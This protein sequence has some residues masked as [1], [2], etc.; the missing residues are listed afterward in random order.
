MQKVILKG[1]IPPEQYE[2]RNCPDVYA[3]TRQNGPL[4]IWNHEKWLA[5]Q[6]QDN[7]IRMLGIYS[8]EKDRY[9]GTCGLT[10]IN[11]T[12]RTAEFSLFI[13]PEFQYKGFG[14]AAL[15]ALLK[16]GFWDLNMETIW[17][18]TFADNPARR[19]FK[20]VGMTEEGVCRSMYEKQGQ[21]IDSVRISILKEEFCA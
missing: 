1:E 18:E 2:W 14:E 16:F 21:R 17:G 3:W 9:V 15:R 11:W 10:S 20:K 7:S 4:P 5:N 19:L 13:A 8:P 12:H 6:A